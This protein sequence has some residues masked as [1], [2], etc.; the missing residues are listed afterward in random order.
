MGSRTS[1]I[2]TASKAVCRTQVPCL[3]ASDQGLIKAEVS[4]DGRQ[5]CRKPG[6]RLS[7]GSRLDHGLLTPP[8]CTQGKT[9]ARSPDPAIISGHSLLRSSQNPHRAVTR[10]RGK[11]PAIRRPDLRQNR[12]PQHLHTPP[13]GLAHHTTLRENCLKP[14][15]TRVIHG[16]FASRPACHHDGRDWVVR[17]I[18]RTRCSDSTPLCEPTRLESCGRSC[19]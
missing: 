14:N 5:H 4:G 19:V 9:A 7:A 10:L 18:P 6:D 16:L 3:L 17:R 13:V 12:C 1:L 2:K 11:S 15:P 8:H